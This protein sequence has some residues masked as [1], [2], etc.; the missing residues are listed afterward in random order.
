MKRPLR[1]LGR[2]ASSH[3]RVLRRRVTA[4]SP[5]TDMVTE[6]LRLV[7]HVLRRYRGMAGLGIE[8]E[9]LYQVGCIGL[10]KAARRF[11]PARGLRFST[12]AVPL[13]LGEIQR[14]LRDTAPAG[15]GRGAYRLAQTARAVEERLA[16][17]LRRA[18]TAAEVAR[19]LGVPIADLAVAME[20]SR[21]PV[22]LDAPLSAGGGSDPGPALHERLTR[23][24]AAGSEVDAALLRTLV[25]RLPAR[26]RAV[27]TL[28]FFRD[29]SQAEVG[30]LLGLSQPQISRL[31]K[32]ALARLRSAWEGRD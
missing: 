10:I 24:W 9:E 8:I 19:E 2:P 23:R 17:A 6:N 14:H 32:R 13:I 28:R 26:Q 1:R 21:R 25:E 22:S 27:L 11:D 12:Y 30:A 5:P 29:H 16:N 3:R 31:E 18:P 4:S 15:V 7:H 20:A